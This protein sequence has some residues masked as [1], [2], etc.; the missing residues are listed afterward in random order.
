MPVTPNTPYCPGI[1][2]MSDLSCGGC[3]RPLAEYKTRAS[4]EL[5]WQHRRGAKVGQTHDLRMQ[6]HAATARVAELEAR[7]AEL[8]ELAG[9]AARLDRIEAKLTAL[10]SGRVEWRPDS[11]RIVD[12]GTPA[13]RQRR[14]AGVPKVKRGR[15]P[16]DGMPELV[17]G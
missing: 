7:N 15:K 11:R 6:L 14:A 13:R 12:G 17:A 5:V 9:D 4:T 10:L 2:V 8:E 16:L 3:G 1:I